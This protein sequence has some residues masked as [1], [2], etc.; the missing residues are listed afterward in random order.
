M[1]QQLIKELMRYYINHNGE[2]KTYAFAQEG[3]FVCNNESFIPQRASTKIIQALENCEIAGA[4]ISLTDMLIVLSK[5]YKAVQEAIPH[6]IAII[7]CSLFGIILLNANKPKTN[8]ATI[9]Y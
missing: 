5:N 4:F 7:N 9:I 1:I 3:D 2:D 8:E 6:I